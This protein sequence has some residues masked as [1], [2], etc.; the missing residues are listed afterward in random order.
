MTNCKD[1][2]QIVTDDDGG[3]ALAHD[4]FDQLQGRLALTDT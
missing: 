2:I 1:F 3:H 4:L